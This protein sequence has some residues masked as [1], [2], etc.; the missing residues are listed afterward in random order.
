V[1][2]LERHGLS[3][4]RKLGQNFLVD[5]NITRRI[6]AAAGVGPG[7]R[8]IE[9]GAGTGTLT[10]ALAATGARVTAFEVDRRLL[11]VLEEVTTGLAVELAMEDATAVDFQERF[12]E[13]GWHL[14][15][16][17]PYN[18]GTPLVMEILRFAPT[19]TRLV[20]MMQREVADRLVARPGS[21]EYGLPSVV[22]G[23]HA[24][25]KMGFRVPPHVFYPVPR[26]DSSIVL[27]DRIEAPVEAERAVELARA[28]FSQRRKMLRGSLRGV[29]QDAESTLV[30]AEIE[31]TS[32]AEDL[33][34]SDFARLARVAP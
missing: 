8:V 16:N 7:D 21:D 15:A 31:P 25:A 5:P 34:P 17:L 24:R 23:L 33:G 6:V 1:A 26:V 30:A 11:P 18:V 19:V 14:V 13:P 4:N 32:R 28:A 29:L 3:P 12:P 9:I 2:L 27:M 20:V 10:R 22:V